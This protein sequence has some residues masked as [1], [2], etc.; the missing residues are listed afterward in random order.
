[1]PTI[2]LV[3]TTYNEEKVIKRCLESVLPYIDY[4]SIGVDVKTTDN[5]K[6]IIE[7]TLKD[8]TGVVFD[9]PWR[10]FADARNQAFEHFT[11]DVDWFLIIDADMVLVDEGFDKES[12]NKD[13][14][15]Y[16]ITIRQGKT[17]WDMN[18]LVN[19]DY[20]WH[21][22][23]ILHEFLDCRDNIQTQEEKLQ[24]LY[25]KHG[26]DGG[27][28][29]KDAAMFKRDADVFLNALVD[30]TDPFMVQRYT[31]Y[32]ANSYRDAGMK[33]ESIIFYRMRAKM[34]GWEQEVYLSHFYAGRGSNNPQDYLNAIYTIP[35]RCDALV[36]FIY[37]GIENHNF[38]IINKGL[39]LCDESVNENRVWDTEGLFFSNRINDLYDWVS[40][41]LSRVGRFDES[42]KMMLR[43]ID[44]YSQDKDFD[45]VE[46]VKNNLALFKKEGH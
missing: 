9:S 24:G 26:G 16:L 41:A 14:T 34:G 13:L 37:Y 5:T 29:P 8:K 40:I 2:G 20:D 1:M 31:F 23:G 35:T 36:E 17:Y 15:G 12:L 45:N 18:W 43:L 6:S 39:E 27:A 33:R 28:R 22:R 4:Y 30:E 21:W 38:E 25:W 19:A 11:W 3:M 42:K 32:L 46:R 10:G 44:I 7:E